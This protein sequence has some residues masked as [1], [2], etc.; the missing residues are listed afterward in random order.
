MSNA[1]TLKVEKRDERGKGENRRLRST[2][3]VPGIFYDKGDNI[4]VKCLHLPLEKAYAP[5]GHLA[6]PEPRHRRRRPPGDHQGAG[7]APL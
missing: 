3:Y 4:A 5:G 2:G 7:E 6:A 1:I